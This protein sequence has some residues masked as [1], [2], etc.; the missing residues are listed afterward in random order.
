MIPRV[1]ILHIT[2]RYSVCEE[3]SL[4]CYRDTGTQLHTHFLPAILFISE[5]PHT[6]KSTVLKK[7]GCAR[8]EA[9]LKV[10]IGRNPLRLVSFSDKSSYPMRTFS[11]GVVEHSL[12]ASSHLGYVVRPCLKQNKEENMFLFENMRLRTTWPLNLQPLSSKHLMEL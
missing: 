4:L 10:F 11:L 1:C 7:A 9:R 12:S 8:H 2:L 6:G 5:R 3:P